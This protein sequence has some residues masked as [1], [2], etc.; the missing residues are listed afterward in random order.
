MDVPMGELPVG[1]PFTTMSNKVVDVIAGHRNMQIHIVFS[2]NRSEK[3]FAVKRHQV[4]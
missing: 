3:I 1:F 2:P 4:E